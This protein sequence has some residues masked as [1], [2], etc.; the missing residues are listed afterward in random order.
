V[1]RTQKQKEKWVI[2]FADG[3]DPDAS[4]LPI[5]LVVEDNPFDLLEQY[6]LSDDGMFGIK[7]A[8]S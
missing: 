1:T 6:K 8:D 5:Y 4:Q 3:N 7:Q 2:D